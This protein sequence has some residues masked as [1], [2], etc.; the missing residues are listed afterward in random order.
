MTRM[1]GAP[2]SDQFDGGFCGVRVIVQS[3][4]H[5]A[6]LHRR[7][8]S[9]LQ[10]ALAELLDTTS[11]ADEKLQEVL[12][13]HIPPPKRLPWAPIAKNAAMFWRGAVCS[14][15]RLCKTWAG[16][17]LGKRVS[18][19]VLL[20]GSMVHPFFDASSR[21][22]RCPGMCYDIVANRFKELR[23]AGIRAASLSQSRLLLKCLCNAREFVFEIAFFVA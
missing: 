9:W 10:P 5:P 22:F 19:S 7:V 21:S 1:K 18:D 12:N 14:T 2:Y 4:K 15:L 8:E 17:S 20:F 3:E 16:V 13:P 11:L 23:T 6:E